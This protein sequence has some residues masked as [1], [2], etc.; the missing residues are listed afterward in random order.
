MSNLQIN[1]KVW[2]LE[3]C[4]GLDLEI[5]DSRASRWKLKP[6]ATTHVGLECIMW[7]KWV[8]C[9]EKEPWS[10]RAWKISTF[11]TEIGMRLRYRETKKEVQRGRRNTRNVTN[12]YSMQFLKWLYSVCWILLMSMSFHVEIAIKVPYIRKS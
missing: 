9:H 5:G 1:T 7:G 11:R 6:S 10:D 2:N 3:E 8:L 12:Q 4:F